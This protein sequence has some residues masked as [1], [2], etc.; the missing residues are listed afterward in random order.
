MPW[1]SDL[2]L[3]ESRQELFLKLIEYDEAEI[4]KGNFK[5]YDIRIKYG[6][7]E[8]TIESKADRLTISTGNI[9]IEY[10]CSGKPSGITSTQADYWVI[11]IEGTRDYYLIPTSEITKA[12]EEHKYT[13]TT[14]GGDGYRSE[15]YLFPRTIFTPY[16]DYI[17]DEI[18]IT[19]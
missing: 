3:G 19:N 14:R 15:M 1:A 12:I 13:R 7:E 2:A 4:M 6:G 11:F 16:L 17:P 18:A 10:R 5:P 8:T 9:A